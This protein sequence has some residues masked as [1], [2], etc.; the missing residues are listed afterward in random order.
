MTT[1]T[2]PA[3]RDWLESAGDDQLEHER[4]RADASLM[5]RTAEAIA[6]N[7][8]DAEQ[9]VRDLHTDVTARL[10]GLRAARDAMNRRIRVLVEQERVIGL[11][12]QRFDRLRDTDAEPIDA[13]VQP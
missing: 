12:V 3:H 8:L 1:P 7:D 11:A 6:R 2:N 9:A 5:L 13:E 4:F 10:A